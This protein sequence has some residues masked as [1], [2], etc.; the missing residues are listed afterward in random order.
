MRI[1]KGKVLSVGVGWLVGWLVYILAEVD[2]M[3]H[4]EM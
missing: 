4:D 1:L 3:E 2:D